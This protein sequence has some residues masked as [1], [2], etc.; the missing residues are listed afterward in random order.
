MS[1]RKLRHQVINLA[2]TYA[3]AVSTVD[4]SWLSTNLSICTRLLASSIS[5]PTSRPAAL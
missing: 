2:E 4:G 1:C 5:M 3:A